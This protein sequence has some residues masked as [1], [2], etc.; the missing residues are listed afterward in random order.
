MNKQLEFSIMDMLGVG[1][2]IFIIAITLELLGCSISREAYMGSISTCIVFAIK[3]LI[4]GKKSD[5]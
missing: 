4:T 1:L 2:V 3:I 5:K